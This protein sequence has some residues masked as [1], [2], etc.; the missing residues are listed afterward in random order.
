MYII[1]KLQKRAADPFM[2]SPVTIACLGD[3][4]THGCFEVF[5]SRH[6]TV[7]TQYRPGEGYVRGL[8]DRLYRLYPAAAANVINA[9]I[10][11]DSAEG[12]LRRFDRDVAVYK[13]DLVTICLGLNDCMQEAIPQA[14]KRYGDCLEALFAK[15]IALGASCILLTPN[16]MCTYADPALGDATLLAIAEQAAARQKEG[17]LTSFVETAKVQAAHAG[18]PVAD[19]YAHWRAMDRAGVDTT[20]LLAN[21]INH[22]VPDM[23]AIFTQCLLDTLLGEQLGEQI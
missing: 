13:P 2:E 23:H 17:V 16:M 5:I 3:S 11:G 4:V 21:R 15:V 9:G 7:D 1:Q 14:Q 10:S 19:A 8:Q 22:P 6:G 18:V 12:A 20:A